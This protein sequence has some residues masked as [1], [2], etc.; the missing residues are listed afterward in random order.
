MCSS[1]REEPSGREVHLEAA[2]WFLGVL[3]RAG[4]LAYL[5][6][7]P[8]GMGLELGTVPLLV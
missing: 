6:H 2:S 8:T 3:D 7:Q 4:G 5:P 1:F